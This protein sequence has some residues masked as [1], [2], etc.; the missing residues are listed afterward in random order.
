MKS[1]VKSVIKEYTVALIYL[2]LIMILTLRSTYVPLSA[3]YCSMYLT[4]INSVCTT[5]P[6]VDDIIFILLISKMRGSDVNKPARCHTAERW[7]NQDLK[8]CSLS[9]EFPCCV[10]NIMIG[11]CGGQVFL[12]QFDR[13]MGHQIFG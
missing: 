6:E 10:S 13:A 3:R 5:V 12:Y 8:G 1:S 4:R 2:V 7:Q 9:L 11:S